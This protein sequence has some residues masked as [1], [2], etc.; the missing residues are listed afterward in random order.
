[1]TSISGPR[2]RP[3]G[4][5]WTHSFTRE[6]ADRLA[7]LRHIKNLPSSSSSA[8]FS[9]LPSTPRSLCLG[10]GLSS[11][12]CYSMI[13]TVTPSKQPPLPSEGKLWWL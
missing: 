4:I 8:T 5:A 10:N 12:G 3:R 1:M 11:W 9:L 6:I 7:P 13:T 2:S